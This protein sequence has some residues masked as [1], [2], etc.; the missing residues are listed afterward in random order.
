MAFRLGLGGKIYAIIGLLS[1][2][3]VATGGLAWWAVETYSAKVAEMQT[4]SALAVL[5]EQVNGLINAV[6]MDSRGIYMSADQA[7]VEK[8]TAP[9]QSNLTAIGRKMDLWETLLPAD[10]RAGFA[11]GKI[12]VAQF[13]RFRNE[14]I[15]VGKANGPAAAREIGDNDVNRASRQRVNAVITRLAADNAARVDKVRDALTELRQRLIA[16]I[17]F[18][19]GLGIALALL[20][21]TVFVRRTVIAP[22]A[23]L[24]RT[25]MQ[26][27]SGDL[28]VTV[29]ATRQTDEIGD[30]ARALLVFAGRLGEIDKMR[31]ERLAAEHLVQH[32]QQRATRQLA[33]FIEDELHNASA[34]AGE[35][36]GALVAIAKK[37]ALAVDEV[38]QGSH[39]VERGASVTSECIQAVAAATEEMSASSREVGRSAEEA[40]LLAHEAVTRADAAGRTVAELTSANG[41]IAEGLRLIEAV[42]AQTNLL[43]LNATIEAARAGE[44]GKGFAVVASEVKQLSQRTAQATKEISEQILGID[45]ATASV[46]EAIDSVAGAIRRINDV[47]G[48]VAAN[49]SAQIMTIGEISQSAQAAASGAED[50]RTSVMMIN[51]GV[52]EANAMA[53]SVRN[54]SAEV[55]AEFVDVER[56]M[57]ITLRGFEAAD[58]RAHPRIPLQMALRISFAGQ[59]V[60]AETLEL[61]KG[62][63]L[64]PMAQRDLVAGTK[65]DLDLAGIG[66]VQARVAGWQPQGLRVSFLGMKADVLDA[67][68]ARLDKAQADE[69]RIRAKL[70]QTARQIEEGLQAGLKSGALRLDDLFDQDYQSIGGTDPQQLTTRYLPFF[71]ALLPG[72]QEPVLD[73]D[74]SIVFC[75]AVDRNGYLPV[76]NKAYSL[77]QG[78]DPVWNNANS[79][80]KRIFADRTGLAAGRN[81]KEFLAQVYA[82]DMGGGKIVLMKD[83]STPIHIGERHWGGLRLGRKLA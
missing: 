76:H 36:A 54:N 82:R 2:L 4:A 40:S 67:L 28:T 60:V 58:R 13:L 55:A 27:S 78:A 5:G 32:E 8:F 69:A 29:P 72:L 21:T 53:S 57:V 65:I 47:A 48:A 42:A 22:L 83:I 52:A 68:T 14:M 7:G 31:E 39:M 18:A 62:G 45:R 26:M 50:F 46:V 64:V 56:R 75:A 10:E 79:R 15:A 20:V 37:L 49:A 19:V 11:E 38:G 30:M 24:T 63:C 74:P 23:G 70:F 51:E 66:L 6:V 80:N 35:Q 1:A 71:E 81:L 73:F 41:R 17:G 34:T 9:M 25:M 3:A 59:T 44:A 33:D 77:P 61:S 12:Q 43:A 16:V